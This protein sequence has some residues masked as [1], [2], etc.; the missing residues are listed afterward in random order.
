MEPAFFNGTWAETEIS[1]W[2]VILP[3]GRISCY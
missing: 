2:E 3:E 1:D